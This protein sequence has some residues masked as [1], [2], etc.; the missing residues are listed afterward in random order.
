LQLQSH[1]LKDLFIREL[2][3]RAVLEEVRLDF[4]PHIRLQKDLRLAAD[5]GDFLASPALTGGLRFPPV[6]LLYE[7]RPA[8]FKPPLGFFPSLRVQAGDLTI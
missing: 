4:I 5:L 7:A 6:A 1:A 8:A 3:S 2:G